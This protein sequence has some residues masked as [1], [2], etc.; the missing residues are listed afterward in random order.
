MDDDAGVRHPIRIGIWSRLLGQAVRF[1]GGH[2]RDSFLTETVGV[3]WS[4]EEGLAGFKLRSRLEA[5]EQLGVGGTRD[6]SACA[7]GSATEFESAAEYF[8]QTGTPAFPTKW[9]GG[10]DSVPL[11]TS[12]RVA[13]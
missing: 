2:E 9:L 10:R 4:V 13:A 1:D 8:T 5:V 6:D 12:L 7:R 11:A 3:L